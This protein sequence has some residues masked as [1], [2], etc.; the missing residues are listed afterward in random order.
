MAAPLR[1][2]PIILAVQR[3]IS[4]PAQAIFSE[5]VT[6]HGASSCDLT[7]SIDHSHRPLRLLPH[8]LGMNFAL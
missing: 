1:C 3:T 4:C 8:R 7:L 2:L 6:H 5:S